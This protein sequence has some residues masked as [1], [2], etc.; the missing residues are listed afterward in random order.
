MVSK[1]ICEYVDFNCPPRKAALEHVVELSN[2]KFVSWQSCW[3][4]VAARHSAIG[5]CRVQSPANE[6]VCAILDIDR[7]GLQANLVTKCS[8]K[9]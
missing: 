6:T 9:N 1:A 5:R 7:G 4:F 3:K 8:G 2:S